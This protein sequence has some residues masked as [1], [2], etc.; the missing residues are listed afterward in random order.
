VNYFYKYIFG[1]AA[2]K[3]C[4]KIEISHDEVKRKSFMEGAE[5]AARYFVRCLEVN[6]REDASTE[7]FLDKFRV[8]DLREALNTLMKE[9]KG[10]TIERTDG[11]GHEE[12]S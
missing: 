4:E 9:T 1:V 2:K 12:D 6:S 11:E 8:A 7:K 3:H 10:A 5:W